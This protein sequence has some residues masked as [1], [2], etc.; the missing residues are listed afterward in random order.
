MIESRLRRRISWPLVIGVAAVSLFVVARSSPETSTIG[1]IARE[2]EA[3]V[4]GLP[5]T[6][7][8][9]RRDARERWVQ[10]R[11]AF[12]LARD[13]SERVLVSQLQEAK[14]RGSL[15]PI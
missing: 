5:E 9:A 10:A 4:I 7:Q 14:E 8:R 13:E 15:P 12:H 3:T 6:V 2:V 1:R 11:A